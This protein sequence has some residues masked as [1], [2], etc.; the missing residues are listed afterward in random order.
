MQRSTTKQWKS[1]EYYAHII[2][3]HNIYENDDNT[4]IHIDTNIYRMI[5]LT[6][7]F[8][9]RYYFYRLQKCLLIQNLTTCKQSF[10]NTI[11]FE[12]GFYEIAIDARGNLIKNRKT[13]EVI[14]IDAN[15]KR[16]N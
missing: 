2:C 16:A 11:R 5:A 13:M 8:K 15:I 3:V 1:D 9:L 10:H 14:Q 7:I 12:N 4:C 6:C